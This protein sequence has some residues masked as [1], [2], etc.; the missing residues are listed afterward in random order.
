MGQVYPFIELIVMDGGSTDESVDIIRR[1]ERHIHHW[2]SE[3]DGGQA[4]A[5][6]AGMRIAT[7]DLVCWLNADDMYCDG[8]L[9]TIA[10]AATAHPGCG[11]Y[12]G[13]GFRLD[14]ST[15]ALTPFSPRSLGFA[16]EALRMGLDYVLQ[17]ATFFSRSAW[18]EAGGLDPTLHFVLDWDVIIRIA[19]RYP[20]TL[21][22]EFVAISR[23]H[24]ATKT[25]SGSLRRTL[26]IAEAARRW[27]GVG[28]TP[29]AAIYLLETLRV[30]LFSHLS[31]AVREP[32]RRAEAEARR[33]LIPIAGSED[34]FPHR[35][36]PQDVIY[37]PLPGR[38]PQRSADRLPHHALRI[39]VVTPSLNQAAFLERAI[40]SVVAQGYPNT[41]LIV[42]DG[43]STDGS[44]EILRSL[45]P[46][47]TRWESATDGGA[48][49]AINKGFAAATG[50]ILG[51]LNSDDML[52]DDALWTVSRAFVEDPDLDMV[53]A[54][55]M[56]VD[57][58]DRPVLVDHGLHQ[59]SFYYGEIQE[60]SRVPA[61]W[62]YI[63]SIPQP[64]VFFRRRLLE[65]HGPLDESYKYIFDFELFFRFSSTA[66]VRKIEKTLA[67][68]RIHDAA[69]TAA[70]ENFCV[71]L[72]RFSRPRWPAPLTREFRSVLRS[73]TEHFMRRVWGDRKQGLAFKATRLIVALMAATAT[74]N[75]ET[76][77]KFAGNRLAR[78]RR[79][80]MPPPRET[81][82]TIDRSVRPRKIDRP[83]IRFKALFSSFFLPRSPGIS[84]GEIRDFHVLQELNRFCELTFV[85]IY[86]P[87]SDSRH[88][89]L[90]EALSEVHDPET[91][92][93]GF[94]DL[95]RPYEL[96]KLQKRR[97]RLEDRLRRNDLPVIGPRYNRDPSVHLA[98][99]R[100]YA[101]G[102]VNRRLAEQTV[103]FVFVSPQT[104]PIGLLL[105]GSESRARF[106][107]GTYDVEIVRARRLRDGLRG[108]KRLGAQLESKRAERF[109]RNN[110]RAF[111]GIIAVSELDRSTFIETY[112][113]DEQRVLSLENGVD[114]EYFAYQERKAAAAPTV[115]FTGNFGYR[116]NHDAAIRLVRRIMPQVW[117]EMPDAQLWIVGSGPNDKLAACSDGKRIFVTGQ[118]ESVRPYFQDAT[119]F[120]APLKSGSGT[121]YK[122]LE[123][124]SSGLP[125]VCTGLATA[126]FAVESGKHLIV[127]DDDRSIAGRIVWL[128]RN[129][130]AAESLARAGRRFVE[131]AHDWRRILPK[132]EP[133]LDRIAQLPRISF[134]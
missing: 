50:D 101:Q 127:A 2:Q 71:E 100:A 5:I 64:T 130:E 13:N 123:A 15:K 113:F 58:G 78:R 39:S 36:D 49:H 27:T 32:L 86:P 82:R 95:I 46:H 70:W 17:P 26:E 61:Y 28:L 23:E 76:I 126:G 133:W 41:E 89:P 115:L 56:F 79:R 73:F 53:L 94:P 22:N 119:V 131:T 19:D 69:K 57:S 92:M 25:A 72:Y 84:G 128:A 118:V 74:V 34:G 91:M 104:N 111:D 59:T 109:E 121:K 3:P 83:G 120:C 65:R 62:S 7:G 110:L 81:R 24:D 117:R 38:E 30:G 44:V 35:V 60:R 114:T 52:A 63:H 96:H 102:Y 125:V 45:E 103:D 11:L 105:D 87:T 67:F 1:H 124:L 106:I 116:P 55:A 43:G 75:P 4:A 77:A 93:Q 12:I 20:V 134:R 68:Y 6:N 9:W 10:K 80:A 122:I 31:D 33:M 47:L 29:G 132:L 21:V 42:M 90:F 85:A 14:E 112:G 48:A 88:D 98:R 37:L 40:R 107:L 66:K 18:S 51:W 129:P 97:K 8:A 99:A 16:R 54:N 108:I